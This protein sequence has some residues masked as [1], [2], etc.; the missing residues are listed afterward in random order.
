M[1]KLARIIKTLILFFPAALV[2]GIEEATER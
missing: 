2:A 1:K